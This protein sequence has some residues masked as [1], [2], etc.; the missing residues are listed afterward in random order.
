MYRKELK[1]SLFILLFLAIYHLFNFIKFLEFYL[2]EKKQFLAPTHRPPSSKEASSTAAST[3]TNIVDQI[4][5]SSMRS[6]AIG[7]A[8][9]FIF[10]FRALLTKYRR[11]K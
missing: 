7:F 10:V 4:T 3:T 5:T 2:I 6:A 11:C 8:W 9:D 1:N